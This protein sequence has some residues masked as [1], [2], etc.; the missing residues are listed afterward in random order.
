MAITFFVR[1][2]SILVIGIVRIGVLV[3]LWILPPAIV[4]IRIVGIA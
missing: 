2:D 1:P 4:A 3:A